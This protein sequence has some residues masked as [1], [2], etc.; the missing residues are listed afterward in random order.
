MK[1]HLKAVGEGISES[2]FL[3]TPSLK[4]AV[5]KINEYLQV[6]EER[7]VPHAKFLFTDHPTW[8]DFYVYPPLANLRALPEWKDA[9]ST[10]IKIMKWMEAM[11]GLDA[12]QKT[13][14]GT[15]G[16]GVA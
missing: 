14:E 1:P 13:I 11:D 12:V 3:Q 16:G 7:T 4:D 9:V 2:E 15:L 5:S 10:S 8:A 6:I